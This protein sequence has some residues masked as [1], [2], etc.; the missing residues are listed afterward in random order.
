MRISRSG[1]IARGAPWVLAAVALATGSG[2]AAGAAM[3]PYPD[4]G[5]PDPVV[6]Q[7]TAS[8]TGDITAY[9]AGSGAAYDE[10]LG[11]Y[12]NGALTPAGFGLDDHTSAIG[13][14]FDFG[15]VAAGSTLVFAVKV[16]TLN[17]AVVYSDPTLNAGFDTD[18]SVGHNHVYSAPYSA[19]SGVLPSSVPSGTYVGFEDLP[20]PG[21]DFNYT[22][23]TYVFTGVSN[24]VA[25]PEPTALAVIGAGLLGLAASRRRRR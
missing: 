2:R 7:F 4:A 17:D 3:I 5:T 15:F 8:G 16:A 22:D 11:L 1:V 23:E 21:S 14:A 9:F 19:A 6:Y 13:Q 25:T 12:V 24:V 18:G 10:T 20:F